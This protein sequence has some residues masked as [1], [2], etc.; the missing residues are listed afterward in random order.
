[1]R[2]SRTPW[3]LAGHARRQRI[4]ISAPHASL[5]SFATAVKRVIP[6]GAAAE[7]LMEQVSAGATTTEATPAGV[8]GVSGAPRQPARARSSP[9]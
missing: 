6:H 4:V 2:W 1:M 9:R 5:A 8:S 3:P 7:P